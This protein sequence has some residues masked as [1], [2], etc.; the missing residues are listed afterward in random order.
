[1]NLC[2]CGCGTLVAG[3]FVHNHHG[4]KSGREYV[5]EDRGWKSPCW[6]W[7]LKISKFGYGKRKIAGK[8]EP[9]HRIFYE[10]KYGKVPEGLCL[11]HLC[12]VRCCVNPDHLEAV[13]ELEN[14]RRGLV[15][16][17]SKKQAASISDMYKSGMSQY[18]IARKFGLQQSQISRILNGVR[19]A[20]IVEKTETRSPVKLTEDQVREI[21]E[22]RASGETYKQL[23]TRFGISNTQVGRIVK[24]ESW[25]TKDSA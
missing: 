9:A 7:Q 20:G 12:R 23:Y 19:W 11:D 17:V 3:R 16:K 22:R 25:R 5:E 6:I 10:A 14:K 8:E 21:R 4:R 13:T 15:A 1:M 18:E 2:A 24:N